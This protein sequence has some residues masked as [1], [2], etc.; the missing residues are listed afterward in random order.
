MAYVDV[1]LRAADGT[2]ALEGFGDAAADGSWFAPLF[3]T[4][5]LAAGTYSV[6]ASCSDGALL[7]EGTYRYAY[8]AAMLTVTSP[9]ILAA[10]IGWPIAEPD[11]FINPI[12]TGFAANSTITVTMKS[13]GVVLGTLAVD[14]HQISRFGFVQIPADA[15]AGSDAI[16]FSEPDGTRLE[17]PIAIVPLPHGPVFAPAVAA[18][19]GVTVTGT[20]CDP[21]PGGSIAVEV[22]VVDRAD[23]VIA[24]TA[25]ANVVDGAWMVT[26]AIPATTTPG[27]YGLGSSASA[28]AFRSTKVAARLP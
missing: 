17:V 26:V 13:S 11:A 4:E 7:T 12:V 3:T 6:L 16:V 14:A 27:A 5:D 19:D 24:Q 15:A 23:A 10:S 20:D 1:I 2:V 28:A 21:A 8:P 18:G 22:Y 25:A 9:A